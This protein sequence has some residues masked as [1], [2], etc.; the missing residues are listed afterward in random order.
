MITPEHLNEY[1]IECANGWHLFILKFVKLILRLET[2][3]IL[4]VCNVFGNPIQPSNLWDEL[5][6]T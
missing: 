4:L 1:A 3:V 6:E 2:K 5:I